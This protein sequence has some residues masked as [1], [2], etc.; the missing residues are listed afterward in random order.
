MEA[1]MYMDEEGK[2]K[3]RKMAIIT[4]FNISFLTIFTCLLSVAE[5]GD[6]LESLSEE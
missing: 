6:L 2:Q 5:I 1:N 3:D 4:T